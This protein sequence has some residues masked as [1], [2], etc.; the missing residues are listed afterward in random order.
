[1]YR[2]AGITRGEIAALKRHGVKSIWIKEGMPLVPLLF[3][4]A[5][6]AYL[7]GNLVSLA[8]SYL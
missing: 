8:I 2:A 3:F 4:G 6:S 5:L 7:F 1:M